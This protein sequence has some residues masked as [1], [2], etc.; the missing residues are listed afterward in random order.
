MIQLKTKKPMMEAMFQK[1]VDKI[2]SKDKNA[3]VSDR[4]VD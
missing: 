1:Q 4:I 2:F 3:A